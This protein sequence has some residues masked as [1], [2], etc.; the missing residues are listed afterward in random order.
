MALY[1]VARYKGRYWAV[2]DREDE[3]VCVTVYRKGAYEVAHRLA[4]A[5]GTL[6]RLGLSPDKSPIVVADRDRDPKYLS[7]RDTRYLTH[8]PK[9]HNNRKKGQYQ[10]G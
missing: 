5:E 7:D 6:S 4:G 9:N 3:L 8:I 2:Y 1:S 10:Y